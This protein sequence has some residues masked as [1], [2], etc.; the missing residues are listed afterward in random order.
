MAGTG[1][2]WAPHRG[3]MMAVHSGDAAVNGEVL[4]KAHGWFMHP[5]RAL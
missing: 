2:L 4:A 5:E 3:L 1:T